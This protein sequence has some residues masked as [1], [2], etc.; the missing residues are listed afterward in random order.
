MLV[1]IKAHV[2]GHGLETKWWKKRESA[3]SAVLKCW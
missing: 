1:E 3:Q 2:P